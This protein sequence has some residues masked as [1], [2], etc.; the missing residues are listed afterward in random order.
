[1]KTFSRG[2]QAC[3]YLLQQSLLDIGLCFVVVNIL[4]GYTFVGSQ[5]E[6]HAFGMSLLIGQPFG[7]GLKL[8]GIGLRYIAIQIANVPAAVLP[9]V[10]MGAC[11]QTDIRR[12][13]PVTGVVLR[14]AV[15]QRKIADLIMDIPMGSQLCHD[16]VVHLHLRIF[17]HCLYH[18]VV[19]QCRQRRTF[20]V[21]QSV[22]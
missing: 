5:T 2:D 16:L 6:H 14:F 8:M 18:A 12:V 22:G 1:M 17:V 20:L 13:V 19:E 15:R 11:T 9:I 10:A 3:V 21:N 7:F 4:H